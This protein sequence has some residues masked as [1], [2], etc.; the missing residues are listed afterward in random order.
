VD[1]GWSV[2]G[3][4]TRLLGACCGLSL[5]AGCVSE[6][7]DA[8]ERLAQLKKNGEELNR[9]A[10]TIEERLMGNQANLHLWQE[11]AERHKRVSAIATANG[12]EHFMAMVKMLDKQEQ[13]ARKLKRSRVASERLLSGAV[14]SNRH[15]SGRRN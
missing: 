14:A 1:E 3:F 6:P 15:R 2:G 4:R 13:K 12:N 11:L 9:A 5:A 8:A 7:R 10:D